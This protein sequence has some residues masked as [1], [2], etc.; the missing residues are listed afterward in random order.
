MTKKDFQII[1]EILAGVLFNMGSRIDDSHIDEAIEYTC[2]TLQ[3]TNPRF[4]R[5]IF[6]KAVKDKI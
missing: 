2:D 1:A 4:D 3:Q 6:T 5:D